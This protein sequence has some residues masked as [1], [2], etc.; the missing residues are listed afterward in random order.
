M[1]LTF[2]CLICARHCA[3]LWIIHHTQQGKAN[4]SWI[5][6]QWYKLHEEK[7]DQ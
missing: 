1:K 7:T 3:K 5:Q 6:G 4:S 2:E